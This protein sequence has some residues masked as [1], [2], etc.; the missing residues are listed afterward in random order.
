MMSFQY[1]TLQYFRPV[2]LKAISTSHIHTIFTIGFVIDPCQE[3]R[4]CTFLF[5]KVIDKFNKAIIN[6]SKLGIIS[7]TIVAYQTKNGYFMLLIR[8]KM[9]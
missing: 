9:V 7:M 1:C 2:L 3:C 6:F 8:L 5:K 4:G